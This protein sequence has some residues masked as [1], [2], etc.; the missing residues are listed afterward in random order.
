MRQDIPLT[1]DGMGNG[2]VR[3]NKHE[4]ATDSFLAQ[5][6]PIEVE[7]ELKPW[8]PSKGVPE[9]IDLESTFQ[10]TQNM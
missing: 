7:R 3:E 9:N 8:T 10:N 4:I 6:H 5:A 2:R 1:G